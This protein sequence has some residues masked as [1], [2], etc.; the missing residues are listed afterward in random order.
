MEEAFAPALDVV[1]EAGDVLESDGS[2]RGES[3]SAPDGEGV[4]GFE[5]D[6]LPFEG[7]G[8]LLGGYGPRWSARSMGAPAA[9]SP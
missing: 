3:A 4:G 5:P 1:A 8:R 6:L 7:A 2:L 9:M